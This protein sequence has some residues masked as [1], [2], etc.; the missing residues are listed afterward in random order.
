M[1]RRIFIVGARVALLSSKQ[2]AFAADY[3]SG[4]FYLKACNNLIEANGLDP[5]SSGV[6]GGTITTMLWASIFLG[7]CEPQEVTT[8]Q[9]ARVAVAFFNKH[10]ER[11]HENAKQ[12]IHEAFKE[13]WPCNK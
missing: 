5:F 12:L 9:G 11:L 10:P 1:T 4:N 6:C 13:A 2:L 8:E 3:H 7:V